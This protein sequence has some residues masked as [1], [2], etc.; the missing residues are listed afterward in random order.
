M[1]HQRIIIEKKPQHNIEGKKLLKDAVDYLGLK[2]IER[3]SV[4]TIYDLVYATREQAKDITDKL[5]FDPAMDMNPVS[6]VE[7]E[8]GELAFRVEYH[9]GQYDQRQHSTEAIIRNYMGFDE[10][11]VVTSRLVKAKGLDEEGMKKL[12][13][14]FI[15]PIEAKEVPLDKFQWQEEKEN[16][17]SIPVVEGFIT[18]DEEQLKKLKREIG[19][20]MDID[21]LT[22]CRDYFRSKD[23]NPTIAELKMLDTYWSD[24]CRHTTFM[25][26]LT[27]V[28]VDA[29]KYQELFQIALDSY[30]ESRQFAHGNSKVISLMDLA[31]INMREITKKGLLDDKEVSDEINA[32]SIEIDVDVDGKTERWLL[33]FKNE[34]HNH[35]TE[36]EPFGGAST[37]L[38]G[39]IRDP[40][41]GRSYVYQAMRIT[42]A[43]DPRRA[44]EETR[45][46]KLPQRK[47][48]RTAMDG[49][50]SYG[51]QIGG[52]SGYIHEV[53]DDGFMAKRMELGALVSAAPK[54]W[55]QRGKPEP[56][57]LVLLIGGETGRDGLGA[58]VG[59]SV[60]Q[61]S[62]ALVTAG[63]EVQKG[64]PPL[65]RK[66]VRL[67]RNPEAT[68]LIKKCNDFGAGGVAVAVGELAD[69]LY[70]DLDKVPVKYPGMDGGEIA[71]SESQERMA[72]V[73][74]EKDLESF[75]NLCLDEDLDVAVIA[76]VTDENRVQMVWK[77]STIIDIDREFIETSG[78]RKKSRVHV[79]EPDGS[80]YLTRLPE[81]IKGENTKE[82]FLANISQ[83]NTCS[84]KGLVE[85][86]DN[87]IGSG[88]IFLQLGGKHQLT[89]QEG[90]A[91]KLPVLNGNTKTC[92]LMTY[93][94][95]PGMAKWSTF[96]GGY[97]A[98]V[99]SLAKIAAMGGDITRARLSFQE[100]YE[101]LGD[102]PIKWAKPFTSL[103]G[104]FTVQKALDIPSI[105]G[106]DSMSGSFEDINVPPS[107]F[108]F[109][110]VSDKV[111]NLF[112]RE[113][114]KAGSTVVL[115][116]LNR[117]KDMLLD[118][119]Q[120]KKEYSRVKELADAGLILS[121]STIKAGGI[122]RAA[123]EMALGNRI[124]FSFDM[125]G[126]EVYMPLIGN[127]LLE[128]DDAAV[129]KANEW[130]WKLVGH[131]QAKEALELGGEEIPLLELQHRY[132]SVLDEVFPIK[133]DGDPFLQELVFTKGEKSFSKIK[134]ARP[135]VLIPIFTGTHGEYDMESAF[136]NAGADVETLVFKSLDRN[137]IEESIGILA[138]RIDNCQILGLAHGF[139]LGN[140]PEA[141]GKLIDILFRNRRLQEAI[142]RHLTVNDGLILGVGTGFNSLMKLGLIEKGK[143]SERN[144][145]STVVSYNRMG[146]FVSKLADIKV[147][148]NL[149]P[150]FN[151]MMVGEIY[152]APVATKEGRVIL[153]RNG[154]S[155][156]GKGQVATQF[157]MGERPTGDGEFNPVGA[158]LA[159]ESMTSPDGRVLGTVS[160]IDRMGADIYKNVQI[161]GQERIFVSGV[162]YF[163]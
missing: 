135:K 119:D 78:I 77:G 101:R 157:V 11:R 117:D 113:F 25:T 150:W 15:N 104:A 140:E 142:E 80:A 121:S 107:L 122:A 20:A 19:F 163:E 42:G 28:K 94:Y 59:S 96:H 40:L 109:A 160:S 13:S 26:E 62:D 58:A 152:T 126:N 88:S 35:P 34:T 131:T 118:M 115:V 45:K 51:Y 65:E 6:K 86:F 48:T 14:Y 53:Y 36:I 52:T 141:A 82:D 67:F 57:D 10:I 132:T 30:M 123:A 3:L 154:Q 37:C 70:I 110:V 137:H 99:E 85:R 47:I 71:L 84:Q 63:A 136:K 38:G 12:K 66:I 111:D 9:K 89:P 105:G 73:I 91:A 134:F 139:L 81:W 68:R 148:S 64:N 98:V 76:K 143:I 149:S 22:H 17:S 21:D 79:V 29:G 125:K 1:E 95:D 72:I 32:A 7:L 133:D 155:M 31:T 16:E 41:S 87:T 106:K 92:S 116:E 46:G 93:G 147:V 55:V 2:G 100:F 158:Q 75:R 145:G 130:G 129:I 90:M 153:G 159:I 97:Y 60:E 74:A 8:D 127:L 49:Y 124:G 161:R 102:D 108:S 120:L 43:A 114:K 4:A 83:L 44:L 39:G 112:S 128:L 54:D 138:Q 33:M 162:R 151:E 144:E 61:K 56:T 5:L 24:H 146:E 156:I 69:G 27:D 50:S 23:R 103:L 18:S